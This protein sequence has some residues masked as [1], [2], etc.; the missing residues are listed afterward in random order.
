[1]ALAVL[2][3]V[4][5]LLVVAGAATLTP[6]PLQ[7]FLLTVSLVSGGLTLLLT[8]GVFLAIAV[9]VLPVCALLI[10]RT[11]SEILD[12]LA[13]ARRAARPRRPT[14]LPATRA[15]NHGDGRHRETA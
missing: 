10:L 1:M 5:F 8:H 3:L 9:T 12:E 14:G 4:L 13:A 15:R 2:L 7:T 6:R 11:A